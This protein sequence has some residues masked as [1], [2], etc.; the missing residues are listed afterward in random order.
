MSEE[1]KESESLGDKAK[2]FA[3]KAKEIINK[4]PFNNLAQKVP[5]LAKFAGYANYAFCVLVLLLLVLILHGVKGKS[6]DMAMSEPTGAIPKWALNE[7]DGDY[8][9][10]DDVQADE[11]AANKNASKQKKTTPAQLSTKWSKEAK[12]AF[13]TAKLVPESDLRYELT[14]DEEG[15]RI[16][17]YTGTAEAI[18][19]PSKIEGLPVR[20]IQKKVFAGDTVEAHVSVVVIPDSITKLGVELFYQNADIEYV[21]LPAALEEIPILCFG[22]C[23]SLEEIVIPNSVTLIKG[24]AF[25]RSGIRTIVV[26]D[27]V[28]EIEEKTFLQC[29]NLELVQLSAN[30][31]EL[32]YAIFG[33]CESIGK[34]VIPNGVETMNSYSLGNASIKELVLPDSMTNMNFFVKDIK[35]INLPASLT[36]CK[37]SL[38]GLEE[39]IIP[40]SLK[41]VD[42]GEKTFEKAQPSLA[43]QKR[44][45]ELGYKGKF[46]Q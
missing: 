5:A 43:T 8:H 46:A 45:R 1:E 42:F 32:P 11:P 2:S 25:A 35:T 10:T 39:V 28:T 15:V 30:I 4:L 19:L 13:K 20:E 22:E 33:E 27:S 12:K 16:T 18:S 41:Q 37:S 21:Q 38:P 6:S 3:G 17:A 40:D 23:E 24:G 26:P 34:L 7:Y 36:S 14:N 29:H 44:L 31:K 9:E